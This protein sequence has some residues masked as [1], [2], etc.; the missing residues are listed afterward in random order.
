MHGM[1]PGVQD[2]YE[3]CA[4]VGNSGALLNA[5]WGRDIDAH[6]MVFRFNQAPT[7]GFEVA[8]GTRTTYE[9]LNSHWLRLLLSPRR[10]GF[11]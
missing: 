2:R 5:K 4:M 3:S 10:R 6:D 1:G 11:P 9:S 7:K 8:V